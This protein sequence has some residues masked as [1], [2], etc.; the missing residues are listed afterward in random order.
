MFG[1]LAQNLCLYPQ[2]TAQRG[3]CFCFEGPQGDCGTDRRGETVRKIKRDFM[4]SELRRL[5]LCAAGLAACLL[6]L[7]RYGSRLA[8]RQ[9]LPLLG[10]AAVIALAALRSAL[11]AHAAVSA[12][13]DHDEYLLEKEYTA[14][15]PI[16]RVWQGEIHMMRSFIVC[17][18]RGRLL[19]I[20]VDIVK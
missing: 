13:T 17:R 11:Q 4:R 16:Y 2:K 18:N 1:Q 5:A 9:P 7:L 20:P 19:F 10:I 6:V 8:F 15:H 12:L 14:P 3:T